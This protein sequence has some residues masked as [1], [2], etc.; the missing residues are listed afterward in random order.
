MVV[1]KGL[2][3]MLDQAGENFNNIIIIRRDQEDKS[4]TMRCDLVFGL[5]QTE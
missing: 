1:L 5:F 2:I 3:S 4:G